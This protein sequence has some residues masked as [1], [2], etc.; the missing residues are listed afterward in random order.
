MTTPSVRILLGA[1][2]LTATLAPLASAAPASFTIN[3]VSANETGCSPDVFTSPDLRVRVLVNGAAVA[4]TEKAQD[5]DA[6]LLAFVVD[7]AA[8]LPA[9]VSFEVEEAEPAG[10]FGTSW[11]ACSVAPGGQTR[12]NVTYRGEA[13]L[14][15]TLRGDGDKAAEVTVVIGTSAPSTPTLQVSQIG[16]AHV[17]VVWSADASGRATG[18]RVASGLIGPVLGS[19][20]GTASGA[21]ISGLCDNHAYTYRLVRDAT[22][23]HVASADVAFTT[24]NVAPSA[25]KVLSATR[26]G[27]VTFES[28]T[29]HDIA[30]FEV[31]AAGSASFA[32]T[33]ATLRATLA[34]SAF[35]RTDATGVALRASDTHV[36]IRSVDTGGLTAV[37]AAFAIDGAAVQGSIVFAQTCSLGAV[38]ATAAASPPPSTPTPPPPPPSP[39]PATPEHV[40]PP[41]CALLEAELEAGERDGAWLHVASGAKLNATLRNVGNRTATVSVEIVDDWPGTVRFEP[42]EGTFNVAANATL[43]VKLLVKAMPGTP[44]TEGVNA[45]VVFRVADEPESASIPLLVDVPADLATD[46]MNS[47]VEVK[48]NE[49]VRAVAAGSQVEASVLLVNKGSYPVT[50][51]AVLAPG[52]R[53]DE[54]IGRIVVAHGYAATPTTTR[55]T[56]APYSKQELTVLLDVPANATVGDNVSAQLR[57]QGNNSVKVEEL[58]PALFNLHVTSAATATATASAG[59]VGVS[60]TFAMVAAGVAGTS[61]AGGFLLWARRDAGR[62]ALA[63]ALYSRLAKSELLDHPGREQ[64]RARIEAEPGV[65]YSDLK[66]ALGMNTGAL[67]HHLRHLE[68]A[69]IIA[70]RR[71]GAFRRFYLVGSAPARAVPVLQVAKLTPMQE[72]VMQELAA[73]PLTQGELAA[74]LGLTQQ[75]ANHH[76]KGMERAG[77]IEPFHDG[78]AWRYRVKAPVEA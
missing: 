23:W 37:S 1:L 28:A 2:L 10:L 40:G 29:S 41:C 58:R 4:V 48:F 35:A 46:P 52:M 38:S 43:R 61:A 22:D 42:Y 27:N 44:Y 55:I 78:R 77:H 70:S 56:L 18:H 30:R 64:I 50:V 31:H 63:A 69:S 66:A 19:A 45:R 3:V 72:R 47:V 8:Q 54:D 21:R 68:R 9:V 20:S 6:P 39:T 33:N 14:V 24:A 11:V 65:C 60:A 74:R 36:V 34:P 51:S 73:G 15:T 76:V 25:A 49:S 53:Y 13:A 16:S 12:A 26:G 32:P 62:F 67:I 71:E 5:R 17:D 59:G 7:A 57:F 75:G